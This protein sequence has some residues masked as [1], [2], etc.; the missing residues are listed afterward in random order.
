M[1]L[2]E[3]NNKKSK[4]NHIPLIVFSI[5]SGIAV[6]GASTIVIIKTIAE[7]NHE[8]LIEQAVDC[9]R[10][11]EKDSSGYVPPAHSTRDSLLE[12]SLRPLAASNWARQQ[13]YMHC[14]EKYGVT[15]DEIDSRL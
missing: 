12:E 3:D 2:P 15:K 5:I 14:T 13:A 10:L 7:K 1:Q 8:S 6:L 4:K 11:R 9:F